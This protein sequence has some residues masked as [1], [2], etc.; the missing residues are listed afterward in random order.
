MH[1]VVPLGPL[2]NVSV[3]VCDIDLEISVRSTDVAQAGEVLRFT[4]DS[5]MIWPVAVPEGVRY[6]GME[7]KIEACGAAEET[8]VLET[9]ART[10][11]PET[12][13]AIASSE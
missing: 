9:L 5:Q 8:P 10:T 12:S 13:F 7:T 3:R 6:E 11:S 1:D 2:S 4:L